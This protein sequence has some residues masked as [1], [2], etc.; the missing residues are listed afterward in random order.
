MI[1]AKKITTNLY[2]ILEDT[3]QNAN[4]S[5]TTTSQEET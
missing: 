4:A 3:L 1:K 2:M 5:V